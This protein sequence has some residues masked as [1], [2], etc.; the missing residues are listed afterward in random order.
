[1]N[2]TR[3]PASKALSRLLAGVAAVASE[4]RSAKTS[5]INDRS[6]KRV[7]KSTADTSFIKPPQAFVQS[8]E[9]VDG[10]CY[11]SVYCPSLSP[12]FSQ[13]AQGVCLL[14]LETGPKRAIDMPVG[15]SRKEAKRKV[16]TG[17]SKTILSQHKDI[18]GQSIAR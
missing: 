4:L 8:G 15:L 13:A 18:I 6:T 17:L 10:L 16:F 5:D 11:E 7:A 2:A 1:L 12:S 3:S 14:Q 9:V